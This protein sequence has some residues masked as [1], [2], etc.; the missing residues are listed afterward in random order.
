MLY[1]AQW[2]IPVPYGREL[3]IPPTNYHLFAVQ[4]EP[5]KTKQIHLKETNIHFLGKGKE[6]GQSAGNDTTERARGMDRKTEDRERESNDS[7]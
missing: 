5:N 7:P 6:N 4:Q 2:Q 3:H 1:Y